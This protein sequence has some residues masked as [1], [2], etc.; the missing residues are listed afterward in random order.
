[1]YLTD[2]LHYICMYVYKK[3][4]VKPV[5]CMAI[6]LGIICNYIYNQ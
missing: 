3:F 6:I 1:M 5:L 2:L 4:W